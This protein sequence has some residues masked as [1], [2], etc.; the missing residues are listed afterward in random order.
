M[1]ERPELNMAI[2]LHITKQESWIE[3]KRNGRYIAESL[4]KQGFIHCSTPEQVISVA[5]FLF[6]G[7]QG[8]VLLCVDEARLDA[9]VKYENL[10]GG[11][12]L[13]PHVYGPIPCDVVVDVLPLRPSDDGA[14]SLPPGL[15]GAGRKDDGS[16]P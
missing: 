13:F 10:E 12:K 9:E 11:Q 5:N 2:I 16:I 4:P 1:K 14:F 8:L 7:Q 15:D 6:R 3:A